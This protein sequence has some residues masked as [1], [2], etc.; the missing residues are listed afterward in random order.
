MTM[1]ALVTVIDGQRQ[2][3]AK[4]IGSN[5]DVDKFI[6]IARTHI[7]ENAALLK[8][9]HVSVVKAMIRLAE[10]NLLP[11]GIEAAITPY[12]GRAKHSPMIQGL[13][14][15]A[16]MSGKISAI[17]TEI[18]YKNDEFEYYMSEAGPK[19]THKPK[20]SGERGDVAG[21]YSIVHTTDSDIP[22]IEY[23]TY[24]EVLA[25]EK[26]SFSK[27]GPWKGPFRGEMIKKSVF[28]RIS[29]RLPRSTD[30]IDFYKK[31]DEQSVPQADPQNDSIEAEAEPV[32]PTE[33]E[34]KLEG[35]ND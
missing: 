24:E 34:A 25:V 12:K 16:R 2:E 32:V 5:I 17:N 33:L 14:K 4:A 20:F 23:M 28:R 18:V 30:L 22:Y 19:L 9:N 26:V 6:R 31:E 11:D 35:A 15:L 1:K 7:S 29:K 8:C 10:M 27:L 13:Y 3:L 21:C